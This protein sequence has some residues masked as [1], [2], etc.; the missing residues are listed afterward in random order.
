MCLELEQY[1]PGS[2]PRELVDVIIMMLVMIRLLKFAKEIVFDYRLKLWM[3][4]LWA[5]IPDHRHTLN[6]IYFF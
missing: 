1:F 4:T 2:F 5:F 3:L 6:S